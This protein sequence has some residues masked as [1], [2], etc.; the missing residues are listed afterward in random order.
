[1]HRKI[2]NHSAGPTVE[3]TNPLCFRQK[4]SS[5]ISK[6]RGKGKAPALLEIDSQ[7][8]VGNSVP[9][10]SRMC[11]LAGGG[12]QDMAL[13][14]GDGLGLTEL[15]AFSCNQHTLQQPGWQESYKPFLSGVC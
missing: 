8:S 6:Q 13:H 14:M 9:C 3:R 10:R 7:S 11:V 2:T 15:P 1:M 12:Q 4:L 5:S